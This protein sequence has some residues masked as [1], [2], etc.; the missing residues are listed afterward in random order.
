MAVPKTLNFVSVSRKPFPS[1]WMLQN[2][3]KFN[4]LILNSK[5]TKKTKFDKKVTP[6]MQIKHEL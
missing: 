6:K 5:V 2:L 4:V 3:L 1:G